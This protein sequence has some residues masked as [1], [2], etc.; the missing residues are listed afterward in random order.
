MLVLD[1]STKKHVLR[2]SNS[3]HTVNHC[4]T[5]AANNIALEN[6]LRPI[7]RITGLFCHNLKV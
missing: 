5:L 2:T 1:K 3:P 6:L 4:K 7:W